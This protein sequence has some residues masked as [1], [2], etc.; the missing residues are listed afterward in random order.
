MLIFIAVCYDK[1]TISIFP[2]ISSKFK[3]TNGHTVCASALWTDKA[4]LNIK[5]D[6]VERTLGTS[7][8]HAR[9]F[10]SEAGI[11]LNQLGL[12]SEKV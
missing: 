1:W 7:L 2:Y 8:T 11:Y 3:N 4:N 12:L 9:V 5:E 10:W 6:I